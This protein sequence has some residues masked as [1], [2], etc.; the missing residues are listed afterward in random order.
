MSDEGEEKVQ[1]MLADPFGPKARP[2]AYVCHVPRITALA[3]EYGY[4]IGLHGSLQ[5]DLD[6]IAVPWSEVAAPAEELVMAI[7]RV[8]GGFML[9]GERAM[10]KPHGRRAWIIH[11]GRALYIDL[12]VM[13]READRAKTGEYEK[14]YEKEKEGERAEGTESS[15]SP[16]TDP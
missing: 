6:L 13:P 12:S 5:R 11:L 3:R 1:A 16:A 9:E 8:V 7:A 10:D 2:I 15:A 14:E 4:A